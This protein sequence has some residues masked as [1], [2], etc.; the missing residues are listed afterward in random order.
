MFDYQ[1]SQAG[2]QVTAYLYDSKGNQV[3][4][5]TQT[6]VQ[7]YNQILMGGGNLTSGGQ[8]PTGMY[9]VRIVAVSGSQKAIGKTKFA[10]K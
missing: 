4:S 8:I 1:C 9:L 5:A 3:W 2:A 7:G 6:A 10:V